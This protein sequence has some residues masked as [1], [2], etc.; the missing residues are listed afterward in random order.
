MHQTMLE[1]G[2]LQEDGEE[3][4]ETDLD[5]DLSV[6]PEDMDFDDF[7]YDAEDV[8]ETGESLEEEEAPEEDK[9]AKREAHDRR[10]VRN[11]QAVRNASKRRQEVMDEIDQR[12]ER[13]SSTNAGRLR[14]KDLKHQIQ[15]LD[16]FEAE[17]E[18]QITTSLLSGTPISIPMT[19]D[20][21]AAKSDDVSADPM[22]TSVNEFMLG[23][24]TR[25]K[26]LS[27]TK[28]SSTT[29]QAQVRYN[30]KRR[31]KTARV[32]HKKDLLMARINERTCGSRK[33]TT[34]TNVDEL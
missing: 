2:F 32:Q 4:T 11:A 17:M 31:A 12:T 23:G 22:A 8:T 1:A 24:S 20:D 7:K 33:A 5:F 25:R 27:G 29:K 26:V 18:A 14:M 21:S 28:A 15:K 30:S 6:G 9:Q 16:E 34:H 19:D 3:I 13:G 10:K